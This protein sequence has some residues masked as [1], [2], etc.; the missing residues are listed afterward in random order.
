MRQTVMRQTATA[1]DGTALEIRSALL[2]EKD[3]PSRPAVVLSED[4]VEVG[5]D[6]RG[7][8]FDTFALARDAAYA[9]FVSRAQARG[10]THYPPV[11]DGRFLLG[12]TTH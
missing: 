11:E 4:G 9:R 3:A 1:P 10:I 8:P 5:S 6:E 7:R 12:W 2:A